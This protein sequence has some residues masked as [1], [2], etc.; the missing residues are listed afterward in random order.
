MGWYAADMRAIGRE[1]QIIRN[2]VRAASED[3]IHQLAVGE[4]VLDT[5]FGDVIGQGD[6]MF[7]GYRT[8]ICEGRRSRFAAVR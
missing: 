1:V 5:I 4:R 8:K 7:A 6:E 3:V 2:D